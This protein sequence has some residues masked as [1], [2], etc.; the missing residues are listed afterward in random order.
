MGRKKGYILLRLQA[1]GWIQPGHNVSL[2]LMAPAKFSLSTQG[3]KEG[4]RT[5]N[6]SVIGQNE[7]IEELLDF[8]SLECG[9]ETVNSVQT[10]TN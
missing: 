3:R 8:F 4:L 10:R 7:S 9:W 2:G 5:N 6:C 1:V